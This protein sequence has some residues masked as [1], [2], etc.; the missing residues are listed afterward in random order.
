MK[1]MDLIP[2]LNTETYLEIYKG[3]SENSRLL[4]YGPIRSMNSFGNP[5]YI[6]KMEIPNNS[7]SIDKS[8]AM[9]ILLGK[10]VISK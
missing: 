6:M 1:L 2:M 5:E 10:G 3:N 9:I 7:I 8:S 4:A